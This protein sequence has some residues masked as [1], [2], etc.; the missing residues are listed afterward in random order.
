MR[1]AL[2]AYRPTMSRA[3]VDLPQPDSP[4]SASVS[5]RWTSKLTPST[6]RSR[7]RGS[8]S[9]TR[10]SQG[11]ETSKSRLTA[12]RLSR[13]MQP[14]G[15]AARLRRH[16]VGTLGGAARE[17]FRAARVEGAARGNGVQ[18]RHRAFDLDQALLVLQ[19]NLGDRA[20]QARGVRMLRVVD[21]VAHRPDLRDA[22][23]VHHGDAVG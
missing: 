18:A 17:A 21:H 7:R 10:L 13:F 20:H 5:P 6:A 9:I 23:G 14:A 16:Q 3:T 12:A 15:G 2:G 4:T 22:P 8:P 19:F 1:P 11:R